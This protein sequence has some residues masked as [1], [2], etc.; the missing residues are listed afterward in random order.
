LNYYINGK[1][2][3]KK[4]KFEE[5]D[6]SDLVGEEDVEPEIVEKKPTKREKLDKKRKIEEYL[7]EHIPLNVNHIRYVL[8]VDPKV[9][10]QVQRSISHDIRFDS[11]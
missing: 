10:F 7:D 4:P 8:I 1:E 3:K 2:D 5:I 6:I 9:I 11:S